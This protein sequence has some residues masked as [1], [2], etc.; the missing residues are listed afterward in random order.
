VQLHVEADLLK[1]G[2]R[3]RAQNLV[4]GVLA[5]TKVPAPD[6]VLSEVPPLYTRSMGYDRFD[7]LSEHG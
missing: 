6:M 1:E 5:F 7:H 2:L 4:A 3:P